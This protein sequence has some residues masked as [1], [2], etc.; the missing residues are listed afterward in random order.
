VEEEILG[1]SLTRLTSKQT[2][3]ELSEIVDIYRNEL[4]RTRSENELQMPK[5]GA[6]IL[7]GEGCWRLKD[8]R[9]Q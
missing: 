2:E 3:K 4:N 9:Y 7:E 5:M 8:C 1:L 6:H